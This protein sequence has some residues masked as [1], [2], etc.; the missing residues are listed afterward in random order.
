MHAPAVERGDFCPW[1]R[2][3]NS[4]TGEKSIPWPDL[5]VKIQDNNTKKHLTKPCT[6]RQ[7]IEGAAVKRTTRDPV[8]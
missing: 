5:L 2:H 6:A 4:L 3:K 7:R 1:M 8:D